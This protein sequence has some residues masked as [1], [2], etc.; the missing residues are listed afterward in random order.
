MMCP[1]C[2]LGGGKKVE[3]GEKVGGAGVGEVD[4]HEKENSVM[5][6]IV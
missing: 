1:R 5:A 2:R 6:K 4:A 3:G